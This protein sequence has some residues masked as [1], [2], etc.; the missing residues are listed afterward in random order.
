MMAG[1]QQ[2]LKRSLPSV[3]GRPI[4]LLPQPPE[5]LDPT[6]CHSRP[7]AEMEAEVPQ[8]KSSPQKTM[9]NGSTG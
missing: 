7:R 4:S 6:A 1:P 2:P 8:P 5:E 9:Q 3:E